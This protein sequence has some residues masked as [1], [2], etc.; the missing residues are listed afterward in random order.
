MPEGIGTAMSA[1]A[2]VSLGKQTARVYVPRI[3]H[4]DWATVHALI[5]VA[6]H[7]AWAILARK[8]KSIRLVGKSTE[9]H[10]LAGDLMKAW[11]WELVEGQIS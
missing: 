4:V 10:R 2:A 8:H 9:L 6:S 11:C 3:V 5:G 7:T 1:S